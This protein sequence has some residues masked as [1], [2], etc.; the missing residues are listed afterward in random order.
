MKLG[1]DNPTARKAMRVATTLTGV[2]A[3]AA[4]FM[5][6][7]TAHAATRPETAT[8]GPDAAH[9]MRIQQ[10]R[11][12]QVAA[13]GLHE[14]YSLWVYVRPSVKTRFQVCGWQHIGGGQWSCTASYSLGTHGYEYV[15]MGSNWN[16]GKV[17]V[18]WNGHLKGSWDTC[19]TNAGGFYGS[20]NP[21]G[22]TVVLYGNGKRGVGPGTPTC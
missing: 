20:S 4:A 8:R 19:N 14:P 5:P 15:Y 2:T 18:W 22:T 3:C 1:L 17:N 16:R 11:G 13:A 6:A 12:L 9:D 21:S 10:A 7:A